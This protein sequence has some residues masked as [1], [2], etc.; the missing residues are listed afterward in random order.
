MSELMNQISNNHNDGQNLSADAEKESA[1]VNNQTPAS[2]ATTSDAPE[3]GWSS[4]A[5][6]INGRFAMVGFIS[7]LF[8]ELLA[9]DS[10]LHWTGLVR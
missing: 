1:D 7:I 3:F 9:N 2:S 10:F 6:R 5:E 4:Y 8:V